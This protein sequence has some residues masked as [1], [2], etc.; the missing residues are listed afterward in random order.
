LLGGGG[1]DSNNNPFDR[2]EQK[3]DKKERER[4]KDFLLFISDFWRFF[5]STFFVLSEDKNK[6]NKGQ[7]KIINRKQSASWQHV[8]QLKASSFCS[9]LKK[10]GC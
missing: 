9:W 2:K 8:S 4:K 7:W 5:V 3:N 10:F 6:S 1:V